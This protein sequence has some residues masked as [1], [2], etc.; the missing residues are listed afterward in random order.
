M[1]IDSFCLRRKVFRTHVNLSACGMKQSRSP[2]V[3]LA[4]EKDSQILRSFIILLIK[5]ES[6]VLIRTIAFI[7]EFKVEAMIII[8][9][10]MALQIYSVTQDGTDSHVIEYERDE[11]RV[12]KIASGQP[13]CLQQLCPSV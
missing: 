8:S 12:T 5:P 9:K 7:D 6:I 10:I 2:V 11:T 13:V 3:L 4:N 1:L